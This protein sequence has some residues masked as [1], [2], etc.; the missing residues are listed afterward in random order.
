MMMACNVL[1]F[2]KKSEQVLTLEMTSPKSSGFNYVT[3]EQP[4][5][6]SV[7]I[8]S[9]STLYFAIDCQIPH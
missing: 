9:N 7:K 3:N 1:I 5:H 2:T 6:Q 8:L 4:H